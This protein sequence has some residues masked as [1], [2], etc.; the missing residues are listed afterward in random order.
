[1]SK[2]AFVAS[3]SSVVSN[4]SSMFLSVIV[5]LLVGSGVLFA[6]ANFFS[7]SKRISLVT[8]VPNFG[9]IRS[10][11]LFKDLLALRALL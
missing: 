10:E 8:V 11:V 1:M 4:C 3:A 7:S 5:G 6:S 2:K 9:L